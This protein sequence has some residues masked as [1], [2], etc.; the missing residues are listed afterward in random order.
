MNDVIVG[1]V[2]RHKGGGLTYRVECILLD[3]TGYES[4][5][6]P[7]PFVLYIQLEKGKYPKGTRWVRKLT[8]FLD[9]FQIVS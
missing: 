2:Y 1:K 4:G 6:T 8:D 7:K 3:A 5:E 9:N